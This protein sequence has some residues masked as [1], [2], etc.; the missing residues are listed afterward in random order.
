MME[1][2][3]KFEFAD[4][5]DRADV[6]AHFLGDALREGPE[7]FKRA[8]GH[9][10]RSQGMS[11]IAKEAGVT[12]AG[13]YKALDVE[14]NPS[15]VTVFKV[16]KALGLRLEPVAE[17]KRAAKKPVRFAGKPIVSP[18]RVA[19]GHRKKRAAAA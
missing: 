8:L 18:A 5:L 4:Y 7:A 15:F 10:A 9:A 16:V 19:A 11:A 3:S 6:V 13:L 14:G 1:E 12:R 17:K 2:V